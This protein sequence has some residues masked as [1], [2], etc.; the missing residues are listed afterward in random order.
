MGYGVVA[1]IGG[2]PDCGRG[3]RQHRGGAGGTVV[4]VRQQFNCGSGIGGDNLSGGAATV[5]SRGED[6]IY[7]RNGGGEVDSDPMADGRAL[8]RRGR[9]TGWVTGRMLVPIDRRSK[10]R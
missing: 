1:A 2:G 10:A 3:R 5:R 7:G 9:V 8:S 4:R 6:N